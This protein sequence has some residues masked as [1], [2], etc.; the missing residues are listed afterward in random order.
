VR[1]G[2]GNTSINSSKRCSMVPKQRFTESC[3]K[4]TLEQGQ[5]GKG[6][7]QQG[8]NSRDILIQNLRMA[9]VGRNLKDSPFPLPATHQL[10]LPRT[11]SNLALKI[12]RSRESTASLGSLSQDLSILGSKLLPNT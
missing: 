12:S 8:E 1:K 7:E 9:Q 6:K 3:G 10:R 11:L 5:N 2:K 4:S